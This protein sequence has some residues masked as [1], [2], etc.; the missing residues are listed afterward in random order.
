MRIDDAEHRFRLYEIDPSGEKGPERELARPGRSCPRIERARENRIEQRRGGERVQLRE[1]LAGIASRPGQ[2]V[3][4]RS[5][6]PRD[7]ANRQSHDEREPFA[8]RGRL[9]QSTIR[10]STARQSGPLTRMIPRPPGPAAEATAA[11]VSSRRGC[12]AV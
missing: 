4:E 1:R 7:P 6:G 2:K 5:P 8:L 9:F 3:D 12:M 10:S 11:I